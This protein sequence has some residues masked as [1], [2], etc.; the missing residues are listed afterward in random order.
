MP[1]EVHVKLRFSVQALLDIDN[2]EFAYWYE[3]ECVA[4][5]GR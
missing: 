1:T 5:N 4:G 2:A 3:L